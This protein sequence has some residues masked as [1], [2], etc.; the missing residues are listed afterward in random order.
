MEYITAQNAAKKWNMS[1]KQLSFY[2]LE[3]LVQ[4]ATII[5][6]EWQIPLDSHKP[7][8]FPILTDNKIKPFIKW[9]GG[10]GQLLEALRNAYPLDLGLKINKYA[11]PF[12]GGG[13]V[14]F[15]ILST[16]SLQEVYISDVNT[17]LINTYKVIKYEVLELIRQLKHLEHCFLELDAEGRKKD[18]YN[19]RENFNNVMSDNIE[20]IN[21]ERAA[22]FIYLNKTCFNGLYRVNT[23]G[24]FNVPMG[25]YKNPK[26]CDEKNLIKASIALYNVHIYNSDY[27]NVL[28][29]ADNNT[30]VYFD[31]P[32]RPLSTTSTFTSYTQNQFNDKD[33]IELAAFI[34]KLSLTGARVLLSNSDPKNIAESDNFFDNLYK[35]KKIDRVKAHRMINCKA[36][37]RGQINELLISNYC[38]R[39]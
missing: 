22:L 1:L 31:P 34:N 38:K 10:K 33:Q 25:N 12:V 37:S 39:S 27:H 18:Y 26:I 13:A 23:R 24:L 5:N 36:E 9:V 14:L 32:Y 21:I 6:N 20:E 8:S 19:K 11:E 28:D 30:F 4:G 15:D 7:Q 17:A 35:D 29:F 3:G 16:Y 2:C